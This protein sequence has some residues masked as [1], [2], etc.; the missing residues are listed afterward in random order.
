MMSRTKQKNKFFAAFLG[1]VLVF[2]MLAVPMAGATNSTPASASPSP[3]PSPAPVGGTPYITA[4]TVQNSAGQEIQKLEAGQKCQIV[5]AITD[6][7]MVALPKWDRDGVCLANVKLTSTTS[8]ATPSLG[9]I[10]TTGVKVNKDS[11]QYAIVLNDIT[12]RGGDNSL[13]FDLS[14]ADG[15]QPLVNLTQKISQC[16]A[17][18]TAVSTIQP[19]V[20][21]KSSSY[22]KASVESGEV[23]TLD[24]TS[25]NTS[26]TVAMNNVVTT[27][28]LPDKLTLAGGSNSVMTSNVAAGGSFSNQFTLMAQPGAETGIA[29]ITVQYTYY[30]ASGSEQLTSSQIITVSIRQPDRFSFASMEVPPE[31]YV[32]EENNISLGFVNK[33]KGILYNLQAEIT[34]N[35]S[36][37]GQS[38]YLGNL[39]PGS[40]G[41]VDFVITSD[42]PGTV[43]GTITLT[44][45][46]IAGN[47]TTQTKE[48]SITVVEKPAFDDGGMQNPD[49]MPPEEPVSAGMPWWGWALIAGGVV[50][51]AVAAVKVV[52]KRKARKEAEL[53]D[54]D[55]DN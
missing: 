33:G 32:G 21:V 5:I 20:M 39:Q 48:Y 13:S 51:A 55:E 9:D 11:I 28:T 14:Y 54:D 15:S 30:S 53:E 38:Q 34:G 49:I 37:P 42:T 3:S 4:Y 7:R 24:L 45:E 41:S 44:Y 31:A 26:S 2:T 27:L 22:G 35:L 25:Y 17:E 1:L 12:Y 29:N 16:S 46:D 6:P 40:E 18:S 10:R 36:N 19:T 43:S 47:Q 8:F 52:K 50:V 23:F